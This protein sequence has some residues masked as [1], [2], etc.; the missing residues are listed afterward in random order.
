MPFLEA[1]I[2]EHEHEHSL[3]DEAAA[4]TGIL[5]SGWRSRKHER[6]TQSAL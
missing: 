5:F 2:F 6:R 4:D 1:T 3:S